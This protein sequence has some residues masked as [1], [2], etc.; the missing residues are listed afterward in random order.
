M[1]D[2]VFIP[3]LQIGVAPKPRGDEFFQ[4][5]IIE[6][7][8]YK[9]E[10]PDFY[11]HHRCDTEYI[12]DA[13]EPEIAY[14]NYKDPVFIDAG[15]G[16]GKFTFDIEVLIPRAQRLGKNMVILSNRSA[17]NLQ[18]KL[19]VIRCVEPE[20]EE[21]LTAKGIKDL[22]YT[23]FDTFR[24]AEE[25]ALAH[26]REIVP[27]GVAIPNMIVLEQMV[28]KSSLV[29]TCIARREEEDHNEV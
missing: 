25:A 8:K 4:S 24:E 16:K 12:R 21:Q 13:L 7:S 19:A 28:F 27:E 3:L 20:L 2:G 1:F 22:Q 26:L 17:L 29:K 9:N 18:Q 23:K 14:W 10:I 5:S 6:T 15:T 11:C